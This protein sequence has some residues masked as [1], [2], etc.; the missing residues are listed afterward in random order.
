MGELKVHAKVRRVGNSLAFLIPATAARKAGLHEG[1]AVVARLE[2]EKG[3][4]F[5]LLKGLLP[6]GPFTRRDFD[7]DRV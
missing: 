5:G 2:K 1:D 3:D 4:L 6:P 7:R